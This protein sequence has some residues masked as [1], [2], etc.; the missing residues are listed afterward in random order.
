MNARTLAIL[1]ASVSLA[2]LAAA[3]GWY[4]AHQ[5]LRESR[6]RFCTDTLH[7][8][9]SLLKENQAIMRELQAEPFKEQDDGIL[10]SYLAK[11]RR[12]VA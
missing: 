1:L 7:P 3:G 6:V 4:H 9:A 11:V 5:A 12:D 8:M 2:A 10:E